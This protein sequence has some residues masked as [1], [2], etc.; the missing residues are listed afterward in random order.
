MESLSELGPALET[1]ILGGQ[2]TS[3]EGWASIAAEARA[4]A[5]SSV[6]AREVFTA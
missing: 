4:R 3:E 2:R 5:E 1:I 6:M